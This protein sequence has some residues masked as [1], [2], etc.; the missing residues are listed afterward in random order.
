MAI[1][2]GFIGVG[3][4]AQG[5]MKRLSEMED[6]ELVA[7][8]DVVKERAEKAANEFGGRAYDNHRDMLDQEELTGVVICTPPLP[9]AILSW[10][11]VNEA[12]ICSSKS[13]W[14]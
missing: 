14:R 4:I 9:T 11:A 10:P 5:H 1:R 12:C 6:V 8:S 3:G 7:Y 2:I 13:P